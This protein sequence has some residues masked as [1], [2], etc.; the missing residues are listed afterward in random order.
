MNSVIFS[1]SLWQPWSLVSSLSLSGQISTLTA[2]NSGQ[3]WRMCS[4][5][6]SASLQGHVGDGTSFSLRAMWQFSL[7]CAERSLTRID[8]CSLDSRWHLFLVRV[9]F[10]SVLM[11]LYLYLPH[12]RDMKKT[13]ILEQD[14]PSM[15]AITIDDYELEACPP[16][17]LHWI[18]HHQEP[19]TWHRIGPEDWDGFHNTC[20]TH[21]T[22]VGKPWTDHKDKDAYIQCLCPQY[23]ALWQQNMD[24]TSTPR[25]KAQLIPSEEPLAYSWQLLARQGD[26]HSSPVPSRPIHLVRKRRLHWLGHV[27]LWTVFHRFWL[28]WE[29]KRRR[30]TQ[31]TMWQRCGWLGCTHT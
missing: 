26:K 1:R 27:H 20:R 10:V 30:R 9:G 13:N 23:S 29:P 4:A 5:V 8:C 12:L 25:K 6:W 3:V 11:M 19:L 16:V 24:H 28:F 17:H 31:M 18:Q 15:P 2:L 22:S 14:T 21:T 7:L